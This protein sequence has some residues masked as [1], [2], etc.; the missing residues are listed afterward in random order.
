MTSVS[1]VLA[2]RLQTDEAISFTVAQIA[3]P[4]EAARNDM[5]Y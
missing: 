5:Y 3:S 1:I 2:R 4:P